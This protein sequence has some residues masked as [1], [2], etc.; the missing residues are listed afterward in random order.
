M[1]NGNG[2]T[3]LTTTNKTTELVQLGEM[4]VASIIERKKKIVEVMHAV[5]KEGEHYGKIPGCGDKPSLYKAGAEILATV[6]GMAPQLEVKRT[7]HPGGHR[8]YEVTCTLV[9]IATGA[10][11]GQGIGCCS[12]MES[13]YRWRRAER[14]CPKCGKE[15]VFRSKNEGEGYYCWRKKDGCG[16]QFPLGDKSIENQ[17]AGRVENPDVADVYNTVL[18]MAKKRAQVDC[19]LTAVGASDV[20]TQ[21]LEDLAANA[22]VY[23]PPATAIDAESKERPTPPANGGK[24]AGGGG[25]PATTSELALELLTEINDA[26]SEA[27]LR[28]L[29]ARCNA[30]PKGSRERSSVRQAFDKRMASVTEPLPQ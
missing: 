24:P 20:L 25:E 16:A 11:V 4:S 30:L 7:D 27:E 28:A 14:K 8:E 15:T 18:K 3:A 17:D 26:R 19:T 5:M 2:T 23:A 12:T 1:N 10:I 22:T 9:H 13:K 6:F 21:D 29:S